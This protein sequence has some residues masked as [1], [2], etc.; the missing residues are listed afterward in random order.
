MLGKGWVMATAWLSRQLR[1]QN[2]HSLYLA[3]AALL[4]AGT[5]V[6]DLLFHHS[7]IDLRLIWALLIVCLVG[8]VSAFSFGQRVPL[9]IGICCVLIFVAAQCYFMSRAD[10]PQSVVSSIQQLP[11]MAFYLGWFV[12]PRLA[13]PLVA[14]SVVAFAIIMA[15]NPQLGSTGAIGGPV[16]VHGIL[17]LLFCYS[18]G[19]Y[20]WRL[21][22]RAA[23]I[24]PLTGVR[25]RLGF[26][27]YLEHRLRRLTPQRGAFCLVAIDFDDFKQLND[28]LGHAAGDAALIETVASWRDEIRSSDAIGRIG[29]DEFVLLLSVGVEECRTVVARLQQRSEWAWSWGVA[30]AR[31]GDD[32]E[33]LLA[34][35][36]RALYSQK[37]LKRGDVRG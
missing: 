31:P 6:L 36:D 8:S 3:F 10:D 19:F 35:A 17:S 26:M 21:Q 2:A 34:C 12:R 11:I 29:G 33:E 23:V 7:M 30:E 25:N 24:D 15:G 5:L 13:V 32:P 20:L 16:A 9:W 37:R 1:R 27:E 18:V 14:L 4:L 28:T 22:M